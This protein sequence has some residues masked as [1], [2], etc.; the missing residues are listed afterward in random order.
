MIRAAVKTYVL[1]DSSKIP[2]TTVLV[3]WRAAGVHHGHHDSGITKRNTLRNSGKR[4]VRL[5]I[6]GFLNFPAYLALYFTA[7]TTPAASS[8][9][10]RQLAYKRFGPPSASRSMKIPI[11]APSAVKRRELILQ[12]IDSLLK[13]SITHSIISSPRRL[14]TQARLVP[15]RT[16]PNSARGK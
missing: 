16:L 1:A 11:C 4:A 6:A 14:E 13:D 8:G 10:V 5:H 7:R 15:R 2:A 3:S 9:L 12:R